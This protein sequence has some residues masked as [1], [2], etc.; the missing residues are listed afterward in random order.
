MIGEQDITVAITA[1]GRARIRS[2][3]RAERIEDL[4][5]HREGPIAWEPYAPDW[6]H[7]AKIVTETEELPESMPSL[8][9][10]S[11]AESFPLGPLF[12]GCFLGGII[13]GLVSLFLEKSC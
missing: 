13:L 2:K 10:V 4:F 11:K 1:D 7:V 3:S 6:Q 9:P 12:F 8:R 5:S